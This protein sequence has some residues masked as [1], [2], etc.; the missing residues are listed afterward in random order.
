MGPGWWPRRLFLRGFGLSLLY[1]LS[2]HALMAGLH[3]AANA[4]GDNEGVTWVPKE[5]REDFLTV[6]VLNLL[7]KHS[8]FLIW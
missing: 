1:A 4:G 7:E 8:G 5:K 6:A 2:N 3:T